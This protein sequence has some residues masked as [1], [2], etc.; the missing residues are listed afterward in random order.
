[1]RKEYVAP[2]VA[3]EYIYLSDSMCNSRGQCIDE[4]DVTDT[5]SG[6]AGGGYVYQR[7]NGDLYYCYGI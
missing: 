2:E 4:D 5:S 3:V 7:E 1:M 6:G